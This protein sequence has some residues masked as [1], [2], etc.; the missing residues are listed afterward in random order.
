MSESTMKYTERNIGVPDIKAEYKVGTATSFLVGYKFSNLRADVEIFSHTNDFKE[1]KNIDTG[2]IFTDVT[3]KSSASTIL[4]SGYYDFRIRKSKLTPY[5]GVGFGSTNFE[6]V[7]DVPF[8]PDFI[9][10]D[11][12]VSSVAITGGLDYAINKKFSIGGAY[13]LINYADAKL[14]DRFDNEITINTDISSAFI[15]SAKYRF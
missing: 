2:E 11:E 13:R 15:F 6:Y 12:K 4:I 5:I 8:Q 1:A 7:M 14:K 9:N 3:V 10:D